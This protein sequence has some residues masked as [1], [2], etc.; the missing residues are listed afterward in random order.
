MITLKMFNS[1]ERGAGVSLV[2]FVYLDQNNIQALL[3]ENALDLF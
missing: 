2:I 3:R 1:M